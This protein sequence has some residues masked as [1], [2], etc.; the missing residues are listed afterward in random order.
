LLQCHPSCCGGRSLFQKEVQ[1]D[2]AGPQFAC[3]WQRQK[4]RAAEAV[5]SRLYAHAPVHSIDDAVEATVREAETLHARTG[6]R[7]QNPS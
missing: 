2:S 6:A 7:S 1:T 4:L 3:R 5:N